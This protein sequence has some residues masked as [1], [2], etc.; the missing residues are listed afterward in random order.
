MS[1]R[2]M[3]LN[4]YNWEIWLRWLGAPVKV[5]L[6][7]LVLIH[8]ELDLRLDLRALRETGDPALIKTV[9]SCKC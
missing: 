8:P 7:C 5:R 9:G 4:Y 6:P 3:N 1:Y 2:R